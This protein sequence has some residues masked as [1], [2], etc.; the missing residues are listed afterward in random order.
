MSRPRWGALAERAAYGISTFTLKNRWPEFE[1]N[2]HA[3]SIRLVL[4]NRIYNR[5]MYLPVAHDYYDSLIVVH[6]FNF[7]YKLT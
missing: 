7:F 1:G 5:K 2:I 4:I 6:F 3:E